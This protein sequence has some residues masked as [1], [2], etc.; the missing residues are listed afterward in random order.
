MYTRLLTIVVVERQ[1]C[2]M[3]VP[4]GCT[5]MTGCTDFLLQTSP[6][7]CVSALSGDSSAA[8]ASST[9]YLGCGLS[10][11]HI[12]TAKTTKPLT[13]MPHV[14]LLSAAAAVAAAAGC[15]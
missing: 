5:F 15:C 7:I 14:V 4:H 10:K 13:N 6:T 3:I 12:D 1:I 11:H 2:F 8:T 9:C